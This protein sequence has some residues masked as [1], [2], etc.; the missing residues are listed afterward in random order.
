M[1]VRVNQ[2]FAQQLLNGKTFGQI[3]YLEAD[4]GIDIGDDFTIMGWDPSADPITLTIRYHVTSTEFVD[5]PNQT[6]GKPK[7]G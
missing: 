7:G 4:V 5:Y 3:T 1:K 6:I 2:H